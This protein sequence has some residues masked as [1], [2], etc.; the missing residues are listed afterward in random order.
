MGIIEIPPLQ[1]PSKGKKNT[2]P[3]L[4]RTNPGGH[5]L[6]LAPSRNPNNLTSTLPITVHSLPDQGSS[7]TTTNDST[8]IPT[9]ILRL[10][11]TILIVPVLYRRRHPHTDHI[12]TLTRMIRIGV[13]GRYRLLLRLPSLTTR[14]ARNR[15]RHRPPPP[16]RP[17]SRPRQSVLRS[18]DD[19]EPGPSSRRSRSRGRRVSWGSVEH[20]GVSAGFAAVEVVNVD[21]Y[22]DRDEGDDTHQSNSNRRGYRQP[23]PSIVTKGTKERGM[24]VSERP[25]QHSR[26]SDSDVDDDLHLSDAV[27][28]PAQVQPK[29][30]PKDNKKVPVVVAPI[31]IIEV[32]DSESEAEKEP[33]APPRGRQKTRAKTPAPPEGTSNSTIGTRGSRR[34]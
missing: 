25:S 20:I 16:P 33:P 11:I 13:E 34:R 26:D 31:D 17:K 24:E 14:K 3:L 9:L 1:V 6:N 15:H 8:R 29:P 27:A 5:G 10:V 21:E 19:D 12:R 23:T 4:V 22:E 28:P 2:L 30:K 7:I 18:D 32:T